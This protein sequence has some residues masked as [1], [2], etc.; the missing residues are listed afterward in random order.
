MLELRETF[1]M[2]RVPGSY[3][4]LC[5][6]PSRQWS[7]QGFRTVLASRGSFSEDLSVLRLLTCY[8]ELLE[9]QNNY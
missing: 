7:N 8:G 5:N 2:V 1:D 4:T 6:Y 9:S 3:L